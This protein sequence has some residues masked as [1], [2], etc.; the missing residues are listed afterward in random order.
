MDMQRS[1]DKSVYAEAERRAVRR[2]Q[3]ADSDSSVV[4]AN[5]S[6]LVMNVSHQIFLP[7]LTE[8]KGRELLWESILVCHVSSSVICQS[9]LRFSPGSPIILK[10]H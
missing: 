7:R 9:F 2:E 6:S 8:M 5:W 10:V 3:A 4:L 1:E